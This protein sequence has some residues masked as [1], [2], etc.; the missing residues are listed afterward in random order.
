MRQKSIYIEV[1]DNQ[2]FTD[3][4]NDMGTEDGITVDIDTVII[5]THASPTRL[6]YGANS[7]DRLTA[8]EIQGL[9]DKEMDALILYGCN[10]GHL[11]YQTVNVAAEFSQKVSGAPTMASDGT[12]YSQHHNSPY[13]YSANNDDEFQRWAGESGRSNNGWLIYQF[14]N[15]DFEVSDSEGYDLCTEQM[16]AAMVV[17]P[18]FFEILGRRVRAFINKMKNKCLD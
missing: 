17:Q 1:V 14:A 10:G 6:T 12:V 9:N 16:L 13:T 4:W 15:G 8:T 2:S 18:S 3:G 5:N 11:D 7:S